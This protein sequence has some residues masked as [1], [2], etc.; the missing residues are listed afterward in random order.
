MIASNRRPAPLLAAGALALALLGPTHGAEPL[1]LNK[2]P[3]PAPNAP[4]REPETGAGGEK[5]D[6]AQTKPA[7]AALQFRQLGSPGLA[8]LGTLT[9][10]EAALDAT[11]WAGTT[12][13]TARQLIA[14]LTR[15]TDSAAVNDLARRLLLVAAPVPTAADAA[16]AESLFGI[17]VAA[18]RRLGYLDDAL[19][20]LARVPAGQAR[21]VHR[22]QSVEIA[23][24]IDRLATACPQVRRAQAASDDLF[25]LRAGIVCD[26][27]DK[28]LQQV[29]LNL[30]LLAE[31]D[32]PESPFIEATTA[33]L[34]GEKISHPVDDS[35]DPATLAMVR[36]GGGALTAEAG[37]GLPG[38]LRTALLRTGSTAY[39]LRLSLAEQAAGWGQISAGDLRALYQNITVG[40]DQ[41]DSVLAV[42][43]TEAV[44]LAC[45]LLF[46]AAEAQG[47]DVTRA[48]YMD[49]AMTL[50]RARG[51]VR[52]AGGPLAQLVAAMTPASHLQWFAPTA[53]DIL[54]AGDEPAAVDP[55]RQLARRNNAEKENTRQRWAKVG[56]LIYLAG[57]AAKTPWDSAVMAAWQ[58]AAPANFADQAAARRVQ[59]TA[60]LEAVGAPLEGALWPATAAG[61]A[62]VADHYGL[63]RRLE[64]ATD[65]GR[66]GESILLTA[67]LLTQA[68]LAK[69]ATAD[70]VAAISALA[71]MDQMPAGRALA[72]EAALARGL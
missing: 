10:A 39:Q 62:M 66:M 32:A 64:D 56:P 63:R 58:A 48:M 54:I 57:S 24:F 60:L 17:R 15:P 35:L 33:F 34:T 13:A 52:T 69:S 9:P 8:S 67:L 26:A 72:L 55:W 59:L 7:R 38:D 14:G 1:P 45:G 47:S 20:L 16:A 11:P 44:A 31:L 50:A 53:V 25:W 6:P 30:T 46:R 3:D 42:A 22:R 61:A 28:R 36:L 12:A 49:H 21:P 40:E 41:L 37:D 51:A 4:G 27:A 5:A 2:R 23:F 43:K 19:A 29:E 18:L 70:V 71:A 68:P 65:A